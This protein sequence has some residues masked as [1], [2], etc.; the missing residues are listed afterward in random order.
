MT[1]GEQLAEAQQERDEAQRG[2]RSLRSELEAA[3]AERDV[4]R[5]EAEGLRMEV[6]RL[7]K[8]LTRVEEIACRSAGPNNPEDVPE[9]ANRDGEELAMI[10]REALGGP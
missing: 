10:A 7:R 4:A 5:G 9:P 2:C 8:A 3:R 1:D 6:A